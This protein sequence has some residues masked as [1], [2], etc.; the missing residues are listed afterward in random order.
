MAARRLLLQFALPPPLDHVLIHH[1]DNRIFVSNQ[2][3][4]SV[5][6]AICTFSTSPRVVDIRD[7]E[8]PNT[9]NSLP[10]HH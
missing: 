5:L 2:T 1:S 4:N 9:L 8:Q 7:G 10:Y 3:G 6:I